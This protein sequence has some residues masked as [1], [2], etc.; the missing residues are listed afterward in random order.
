M[1]KLIFAFLLFSS[2]FGFSQKMKFKNDQILFD[3]NPV[4]N[5]TREKGVFTLSKIDNSET[6]SIT[7]ENCPIS[8]KFYLE[9]TNI[10]T[11]TKNQMPLTSYSAMNEKKYVAIALEEAGFVSVDGLKTTKINDFINGQQFDL[12]REYSCKMYTEGK[13]KIAQMNIK[14]LKNGQ[15][16]KNNNIVV[17]YISRSIAINVIKYEVHTYNFTDAKG[18][19]IA[20][21]TGTKINGFPN[22]IL[23]T[24]D[25][26]E[27]K[28]PM[29]EFFFSNYNIAEDENVQ[30]MLILLIQNGYSL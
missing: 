25:K 26:K 6:V 9:F 21:A 14:V 28:I 18:N 4:A 3:K 20:S 23:T 7:V 17:G 29:K 30:M 16:T 11:Q 1:K 22:S 8:G 12:A 10:T 24:N 2:F 19:F 13:E 5:L 15:I 27:F